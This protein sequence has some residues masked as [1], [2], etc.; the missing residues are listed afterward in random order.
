MPVEAISIAPQFF[1]F[2]SPQSGPKKWGPPPGLQKKF[3]QNPHRTLQSGPVKSSLHF[4]N[5]SSSY[6]LTGLGQIQSEEK[7]RNK[8][9]L[10]LIKIGYY[11]F[12]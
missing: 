5:L 7:V 9:T 4:I 11:V 2:I 3:L 6:G 10:S 12:I 1:T 8:K